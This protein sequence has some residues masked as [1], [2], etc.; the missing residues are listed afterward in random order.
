MTFP[1]KTRLVEIVPFTRGKDQ[2]CTRQGY[3]YYFNPLTTLFPL[4]SLF[5]TQ[6]TKTNLIRPTFMLPLLISSPF[7][8]YLL[9]SFSTAHTP[10]WKEKESFGDTCLHNIYN[11]QQKSL[12]VYS[13]CLPINHNNK[14]LKR[15]LFY[16][17]IR[18][19]SI[20]I[21]YTFVIIATNK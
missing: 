1:E 12:S 7:P 10:V 6:N 11:I 19:Y 3:I 13:P 21:K 5:T 20:I 4:P 14:K 16:E 17:A 8:P 9:W 15:P 2:E 18:P